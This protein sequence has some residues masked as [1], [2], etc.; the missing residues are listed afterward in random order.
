MRRASQIAVFSAS[1]LLGVAAIA[2]V[3]LVLARLRIVVIPV[4]AALFVTAILS[5][6][7]RWLRARGAP[8]TLAALGAIVGFLIALA[9]A[10]GLVVPSVVREFASL[11]TGVRQ[12]LGQVGAWLAQGPLGFSQQEIDRVVD[13][14]LSGLGLGGTGGLV[15]GLLT[16]AVVAAEVL[17]GAVLAVVLAFFFVRDGPSMSRWV[18]DCLP[19]AM[20]ET[21]WLRAHAAW[22]T[23]RDYVGGI[24][25]VAVADTLG[26]GLALLLIGVPLVVP[27]MVLV[28]LGA[29]FPVIGATVAGLVAVLVALV[30]KGGFAALLTL[31]A[32]LLVQQIE[33]NLLYPVIVGRRVRLHPAV[34]LLSFAIGASA[35]GVLGALVAVPL[36]ATIG[37]AIKLPVE[38]ST[39]PEADRVQP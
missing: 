6:P 23:L 20:R 32:V 10:V 12:G 26:I 9:A 15:Q 11:E 36:A 39:L 24:A 25:V 35:A 14:S 29:F 4:V 16:G 37:S 31:A 21:A 28:F 34:T 38:E 8:P 19:G 2:V 13:R 1:F 30:A 7:F 17:A 3:A 33:G 5:V 27:L 22:S 18:V